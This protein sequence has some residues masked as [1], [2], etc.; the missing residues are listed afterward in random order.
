MAPGH[1]CS[2]TVPVRHIKHQE[3]PKLNIANLPFLPRARHVASQ[4]Q[5][6]KSTNKKSG[7]MAALISAARA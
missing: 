5:Q 7:R 6:T 2:T 3:Y 4:A 1:G